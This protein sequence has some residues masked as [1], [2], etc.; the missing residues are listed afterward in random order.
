[1]GRSTRVSDAEL[2]AILRQQSRVISREQAVAAGLTKHA[3]QHRL[4]DRGPWQVLLPGIY[5]AATGTVSHAQR[6]LA[7]L[8]YAGPDAMLTGLSALVYHKMRVGQPAIVD[9]LV[10]VT[11]QRRDAEFVRLRR[12][13]R[14]PESACRLEYLR[15]APAA[16][17][18]GDAVRGMPSLRDVRAVV[19]DAVQRRRCELRE[20]I[21]ELNAGPS[22]HSAL[23]REALGEVADG[24]RSVAEAE[25][26][27]LIER[28]GLEMPLFNAEIYDGDRHIATP[29]AWYP[30]YGI[31]I[32]V[33]SVE[34]HTSPRD[35]ARTLERGN[36]MQTYLI[37]VLRFTPAKV[38]KQPGQVIAEIRAAIERA[39]G[40][41]G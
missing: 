33:D 31:A 16:R 2:S 14:M 9:V 27:A 37:N 12:T 13:A 5:L 29:D 18:V 35:H 20:L 34:W 17:A 39:R 15:Y 21:D 26:R 22:R 10:P 4:R 30:Q 19:A 23:F 41:R 38:R 11:C 40:D 3:L 8:L 32:E 6:D 1:M 28:A 25:L 36:R 24:S 7:A